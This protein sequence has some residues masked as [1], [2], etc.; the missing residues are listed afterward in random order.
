MVF[1]RFVEDVHGVVG[2]TAAGFG[3]I[4]DEAGVADAAYVDA[5][6]LMVVFAPAFAGLFADAIDRSRFHD[7]DLRVLSRGVV[8]PKTAMELGQKSLNFSSRARSSTPSR[9]S[10]FRRQADFTF[11]RRLLKARQRGGTPG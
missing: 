3:L 6:L 8:G 4:P 7:G 10:M 5:E 2:G 1:E 11:A 9:P